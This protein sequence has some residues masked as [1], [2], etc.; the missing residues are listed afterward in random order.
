MIYSKEQVR[1]SNILNEFEVHNQVGRVLK[2]VS[3]NIIIIT[4]VLSI[5]FFSQTT[6]DELI[7]KY[8]KE[9]NAFLIDRD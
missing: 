4:E 3:I 8:L 2:K 6:K 7:G 5:P 1:A 9:M